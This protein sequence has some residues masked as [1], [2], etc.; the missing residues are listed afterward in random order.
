LAFN[1]PLALDKASGVLAV[2][3]RAPA[4]LALFEA[5]SGARRQTLETCGDTDDL[6]FDAPRRRLYVVC[7]SG[8]VDVFQAGPGGYVRLARIDSRRGA[9]TGL[10][11]PGLDRLFIA[12]RA[13]FGRRDAAILV[14]RPGP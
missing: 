12:A 10:F 4:K 2:G 3:Y 7:G 6:F 14:F 5:A 9:R 11:V 8:G 13:G 1:F